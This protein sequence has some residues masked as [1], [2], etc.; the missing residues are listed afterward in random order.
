MNVTIVDRATMDSR[1]GT[2]AFRGVVLRSIQI[3]GRC[4]ICGGLRGIPKKE[5]FH[6]FGEFYYVDTW[7]NSCGHL[8]KYET[9]LKE[10]AQ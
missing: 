8:D 3:S 5:R 1:W 4:P 7:K 9:V 2:S 10:T 6:E